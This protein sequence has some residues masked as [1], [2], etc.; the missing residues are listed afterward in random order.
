MP[1]GVR[2]EDTH[3]LS[4]SKSLHRATFLENNLCPA[5]CKSILM[6][7]LPEAGCDF[8]IWGVSSFCNHPIKTLITLTASSDTP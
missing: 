4:P 1:A 8:P 7:T 2:S 5:F 3:I 6:H